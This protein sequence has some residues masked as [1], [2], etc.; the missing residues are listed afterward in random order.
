MRPRFGILSTGPSKTTLEKTVTISVIMPAYNAQRFIGEALDSIVAQ[1]HQV[2][3]II[4]VDDGS[5]DRTV[6]IVKGRGDERIKLITQPQNCGA[7]AARHVGTLAAAGKFLCYLDADDRLAPRALEVLNS[8]LSR[9]PGA[10][11]AYADSLFVDQSGNRLGQR[12]IIRPIVRRFLNSRRNPSGE[13]LR[14]FLEDNH[15]TNGGVALVRKEAVLATQCWNSHLRF[16]EDWAAWTLLATE[17]HFLYVPNFV[18]LEYRIVP[19]GLSHTVSVD[20]ASNRPALDFVFGNPRVTGKI[21]IL[22]LLRLR[23]LREAH[24]RLYVAWLYV[25]KRLWR[26]SFNSF[27]EAVA[28]APARAP[29]FAVRYI[30]GILNVLATR[31]APAQSITQRSPLTLTHREETVRKDPAHRA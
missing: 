18:A 10:V 30:L 4:V 29:L 17:G 8:A 14:G 24:F 19:T 13:V 7:G 21:D 9:K 15:L 23:K 16:E 6:E 28:L 22:E 1:S 26:A 3:E 2:L 12:Q 27:K 25:V 5:K 31:R 11:L 20:A